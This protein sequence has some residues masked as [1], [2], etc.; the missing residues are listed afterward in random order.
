MHAHTYVYM[1]ACHNL[2]TW[3]TT[4]AALT[5]TSRAF[6]SYIYI[7]I[8]GVDPGVYLEKNSFRTYIYIR[9]RP[10]GRPST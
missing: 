1:A 6:R 3:L 4:L 7:Y 5:F 9:G 8:Y 10:L 2:G